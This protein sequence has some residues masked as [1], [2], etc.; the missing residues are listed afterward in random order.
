MLHRV[1]QKVVQLFGE[2]H[3]HPSAATPPAL[4]LNDALAAVR[5]AY[6]AGF[7]GTVPERWKR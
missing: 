2:K 5:P 7:K 4:S 1:L 3:V 6:P